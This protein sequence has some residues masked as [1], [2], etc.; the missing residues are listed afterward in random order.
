MWCRGGKGCGVEM[1]RGW[2]RGREE[3]VQGVCMG[4][5]ESLTF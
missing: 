4:R 3:I 5:N 2:C 1:G